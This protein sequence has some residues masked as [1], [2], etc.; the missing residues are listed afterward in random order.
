MFES[1][2]E[3]H[4]I[5]KA[6][7]DAEEPKLRGEL[8]D[9]QFDLLE[10]GNASVVAL[11]L[12]MDVVGRSASAKQLMSWMDPRHIRPFA[13]I[14]PSDEERGRPRMWRFW[15]ALPGKG[16]IGIFLSSWYEGPI[17]DYFVGR[18][19]KAQFM[20]H[21][22][23]IYRF[24]EMLANEGVQL[25]KFLYLLPKKQHL[26]AMK[27]LSKSS[28]AAWKV[29]DLDMTFMKAFNKRYDAMLDVA[30]ELVGK[31][32]TVY[33]PWIPIACADRRYRDLT[34]GR[35]VRDAIRSVLKDASVPTP[36]TDPDAW[37]PRG[38]AIS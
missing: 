14:R 3:P 30:E 34:V 17:D 22:E 20:A 6:E 11:I 19:D 23:E 37:V 38:G 32:S 35:T 24:E 1:L 28:T 29:S 31:T 9:A 2:L 18:T 33:A 7:F 13:M 5:S 4:K 26:K 16:R 25:L 27:K 15:R 8:I 21:V 12:G 36:K 10:A